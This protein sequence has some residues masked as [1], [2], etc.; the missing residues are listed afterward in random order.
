ML[1][2]L[3][4]D[5]VRHGE[6]PVVLTAERVGGPVCIA[7]RDH[8]AGAPAERL[9]SLFERLVGDSDHPASVGL[10]K[11]IVRLLVEAH[12]GHLGYEPADPGARFVVTLPDGGGGGAGEGASTGTSQLSGR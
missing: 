4:A 12:G 8:G 9:S 3:L 7:L 11:W 10:G 6:P 1:I 5:A 2:N